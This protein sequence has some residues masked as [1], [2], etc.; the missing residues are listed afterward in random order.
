MVASD[1]L[2]C[3]VKRGSVPDEFL[4]NDAGWRGTNMSHNPG[5]NAI[6]ACRRMGP[7]RNAR[8]GLGL[9]LALAPTPRPSVRLGRPGGGSAVALRVALQVRRGLRSPFQQAHRR[10]RR[11]GRDGS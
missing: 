9:T 5:A 2:A 4:T 8:S 3:Q 7:M 10:V 6:S 1:L 11:R